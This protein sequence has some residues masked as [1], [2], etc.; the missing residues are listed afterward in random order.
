MMDD[1]T[2][3]DSKPSPEQ[4]RTRREPPTI[5][6]EASEITEKGPDAGDE[7]STRQSFASPRFSIAAIA[8]ILTAAATGAVVAVLAI[9]GAWGTGWLG[10]S[11]QPIVRTENNASAIAG[12]SSRVA[13]VEGKMTKAAAPDPSLPARFDAQDKSIAA[14]RAELAS[15][16]ARSEKLASELDAIRSAPPSAPMQ[17]APPDLSAIEERLNQIERTMRTDSD[18]IAQTADKPADDIA[19]R[20]VVV[21]SLLDLS[22]RHG[23]PFASTL[24][25]AKTLAGDGDALKPLEEF[26]AAGVP[27]PANLTRELLTLVPKLSPPPPANT[28]GTGIVERLKAGATKL[29]RVE[30]SDATGNDRGAIVARITAAAVRNDLPDARRE[31]EQLTPADREPAQGWLDKVK[32]RDAALAASRQFASQAM[33]ALAKPAP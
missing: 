28:T 21:A 17:A 6:L 32:A 31:V 20:R 29:V 15:A 9:L 18:K 30:R 14:L 26:A 16:R 12:L 2:P 4:G 10:E 23:E 22:V 5:D 25:T 24:A 3:D 8:P 33:A 11:S 7:S 19:L 27:N 1:N 13:E